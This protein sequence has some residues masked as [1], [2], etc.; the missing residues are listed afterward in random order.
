MSDRASARPAA[1][2]SLVVVAAVLA[3]AIGA[4]IVATAASQEGR[5]VLTMVGS[6]IVPVAIVALF[7]LATKVGMLA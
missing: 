7:A 4:V 2:V 1:L 6:Q 3:I 5:D